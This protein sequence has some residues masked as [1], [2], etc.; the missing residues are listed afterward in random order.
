M[1]GAFGRDVGHVGPVRA[2]HTCYQQA[3]KLIVIDTLT[4]ERLWERH[5]IPVGT[6][7]CGDDERVALWT[8]EHRHCEVLDL[9]DGATLFHAV[10]P[11]ARNSVW[12]EARGRIWTMSAAESPVITCHDLLQDRKLWSRP[13]PKDGFPLLLDGRTGAVLDP[14]GTLT[15]LDLESG[16]PLDEPLT[17]SCPGTVE[18]IWAGRDAWRW[19]V[20]ISGPSERSLEW[21]AAQPLNGYRR[22]V[23]HG[24]LLAIHRASRQIEWKQELTGEPWPVDQYQS[25][26]LLVRCYKE[27]PATGGSGVGDGVLRVIDKRTGRELAAHRHLNLLPYYSFEPQP[28]YQKLKVRTNDET[29]QFDYAAPP[30]E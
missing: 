12:H 2:R 28:E 21:L 11:F 9:A 6:I 10:C 1:I 14:Q 24:P 19:Y 16:T 22:P 8:P 13:L 18:R 15:L 30:G 3:G 4:G 7:P 5:D 20:A 25:S 26:P 27:P 29:L 17:I 23:I